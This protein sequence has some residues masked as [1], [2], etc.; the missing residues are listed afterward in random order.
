MKKKLLFVNACLMKESS[1]T[2]RLC[3]TVLANF[4]DCEIIEADLSALALKPMMKEDVIKR[5][6]ST[7]LADFSLAN[8]FANADIIVFGAPYWD[9]SFPAALKAY[10]EQICINKITF[11]YTENGPQ[12]LC[13]AKRFIYV[14]TSG[15]YIEDRN[16][17]FDYI[18]ALCKILGVEDSHFISAQG[19][20]IEGADVEGILS[21]A[22][23]E[24]SL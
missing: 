11:K 10:I 1:R 14:T 18:K 19:L 20:D 22:E 4:N 17:G 3:K 6:S 13:K 15:G 8:D 23:S 12:G 24:I 21:R 7:N 2:L 16:F 9:L 5:D